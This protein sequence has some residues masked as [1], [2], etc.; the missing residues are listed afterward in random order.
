MKIYTTSGE[1][2]RRLLNLSI[3]TF[4]RRVDLSDIYSKFS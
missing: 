4:L 1:I 3:A 2:S